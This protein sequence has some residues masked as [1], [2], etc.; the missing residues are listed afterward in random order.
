VQLQA[1]VTSKGTVDK[2]RAVS[3]HPLLV[4]AATDAVKRW[5]YEPFKADGEPVDK[6][7]SITLNFKIPR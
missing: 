7:I 3:G 5:R 6:E 2:V 4:Q 1:I